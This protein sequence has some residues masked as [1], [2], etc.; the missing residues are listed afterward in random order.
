MPYEEVCDYPIFGLSDGLFLPLSWTYTP[1]TAPVAAVEC[2]P[3][4]P[5]PVYESPT[6]TTPA[7]MTIKVLTKSGT[8]T[9]DM[10][11]YLVGVLAAEMPASFESEAL[12]AQAVAARTYALYCV[13]SSR[14]AGGQICTDFSCC[15]SWIDD[16][17]LRELWGSNYEAN[18]QK[19]TRAVNDT[20][21]QYLEYDGKVIFAAFHSSSAAATEDCASIWSATPYLVSVDSPETAADVPDY[22]SYVQCTPLDFRDTVLYAFPDA[23]FTGDEDQWIGACTLDGSG[24][25][26]L[27][28]L[29]GVA[30]DGSKLR[31]LFKLRSTAFQLN[32]QDGQFIF[33]VTG[34]GHGVGMSQYGANV[35]AKNGSDYT[36]ILSHYYQGTTLT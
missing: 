21:G 34:Y 31:S 32:F 9:M 11:E 15:Q 17:S 8:V 4:S 35:M 14:H 25:V 19:I 6:I 16:T 2:A 7:P 23:G 36:A 26:A 18:L 13:N 1:Q 29:G 30:I 20:A 12:K 27:I 24:R 3:A 22:V 33:T 28:E 5:T 10:Q